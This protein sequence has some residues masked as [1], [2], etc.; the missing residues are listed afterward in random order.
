MHV[1]AGAGVRTFYGAR[2][3]ANGG[4]AGNPDLPYTAIMLHFEGGSIVDSSPSPKSFTVWGSA[5]QSTSDPKFGEKCLETTIGFDGCGLYFNGSFPAIGTAPFAYD[6]WIKIAS[7]S[8]EQIV[9]DTRAT[10]GGGGG[11]VLVQHPSLGLVAV[12]S[13]VSR[14]NGTSLTA[15][16]WCHVEV[17]RDED[18][19]GRFFLGGTKLAEYT[20]DRNY[21]STQC[22]L[23]GGTYSP[24]GVLQA[25]GKYDEFRLLVGKGGHTANFTP[26]IA[27]YSDT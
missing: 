27:A 5:V 16:T 22:F 13:G 24:V 18:M 15:G 12:Q 14:Y 9:L 25:V 6:F 26:P 7:L 8:S 20:D 23:G 19:V 10:S 21:T 1:G 2:L 3:L 4:P 17:G 11:M